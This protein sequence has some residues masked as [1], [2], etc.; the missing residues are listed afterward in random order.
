MTQNQ[1]SV[2]KTGINDRLT[3]QHVAA[4]PTIA[5]RFELAKAALVEDYSARITLTRDFTLGDMEA[6]TSGLP[7]EDH[8]L[9]KNAI[10]LFF[11]PNPLGLPETVIAMFARAKRELIATFE[12]Y[13]ELAVAFSAA[14]MDG[15]HQT[16]IREQSGFDWAF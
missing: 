4:A 1:L 14:D 5:A 16:V 6:N 15:R 12:R 11:V 7:A 3:L 10:N 9:I 2:I 8:Q 13:R